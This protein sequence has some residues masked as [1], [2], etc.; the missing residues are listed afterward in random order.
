MVNCCS[1]TKR[2]LINTSCLYDSAG[3]SW[4]KELTIRLVWLWCDCVYSMNCWVRRWQHLG[5]KTLPTSFTKSNR[6]SNQVGVYVHS[7]SL[8][9][10]SLSCLT[11]LGATGLG[12]LLD[13]DTYLG[14]VNSPPTR[15]YNLIRLSL[16]CL[17]GPTCMHGRLHGPPSPPLYR[18]TFSLRQLC[19]HWYATCL[20]LQAKLQPIIHTMLAP[21]H[22][23]QSPA[24]YPQGF[25]LHSDS[26]V[27]NADAAIH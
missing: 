10:L 21:P 19:W 2:Q 11:G 18:P 16:S 14:F 24:H 25:H 22:P 6:S 17:S 3:G 5:A 27:T 15:L 20:P 13:N 8:S 7:H 9:R 1:V 26:S 23:S 12:P 4:K